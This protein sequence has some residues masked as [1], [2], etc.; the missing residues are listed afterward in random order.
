MDFLIADPFTVEFDRHS[1][2]ARDND[3]TVAELGRIEGSDFT[4]RE[5]LGSNITSSGVSC[6]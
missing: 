5:K 3:I 2:D 1:I 6:A 4:A